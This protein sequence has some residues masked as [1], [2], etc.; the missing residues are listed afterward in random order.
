MRHRFVVR[1]VVRPAIG[2]ALSFVAWGCNK[3]APPPELARAD[4]VQAS[5]A[6]S[7]AETLAPQA[8]ARADQLLREAHQLLNAGQQE[9]A[10]IVA[11]QA[12]AAYERTQ[13]LLRKTNAQRRV[14]TAQAELEAKREEL[15][16]L[17]AETTRTAQEA[18]ALELRAKVA[19]D[20]E[21]VNDVSLLSADRAAARQKAALQLS[22]EARSLCQAA[23]LIG[24]SPNQL[25]ETR[26]ALDQL[27]TELVAGSLRADL[28]PRARELRTRC[29]SALTKA[30][31]AQA[32]EKPENPAPDQLL[33]QLSETEHHFV[34]RDERGVV[35]LLPL[36]PSVALDDKVRT[37]LTELG[38]IASVQKQFPLL[39]IA[40]TG[41]KK[42]KDL[43]SAWLKEAVDVLTAAGAPRI[44]SQ[45][46]LD[47][48]PLVDRRVQIAEQKN[49][50]LEIVF[51][52]PSY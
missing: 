22:S 44:A 40:H 33:S 29:L 20:R 49:R 42:E 10:A 35:A 3:A 31:R 38:K 8:K 1:G 26:A 46:A 28:F 27:E 47:R 16:K 4:S 52:S 2:L 17:D 6:L 9:E 37:R 14:E 23:E 32:L 11:R 5:P 51:V 43:A 41:Q 13:A 7:E 15:Q 18:E 34:I 45:L 50:R 30:R 36:E 21:P 48:Q 12:L 19:L 25:A 39:V 24:G